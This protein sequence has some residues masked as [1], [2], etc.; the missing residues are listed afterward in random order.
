[1]EEPIEGVYFDWLCA[2]VLTE[3]NSVY[4]ELMNILYRTEFEWIVV[5]DENRFAEGLELREYFLHES[6]FNNDSEW[7]SEPCSTLEALIAFANRASFQTDDPLREWFWRFMNNLGLDEYRQVGI[8]DE[9]IIEEILSTFIWRT[10]DDN[11][12]GG[13]FPLRTPKRDQTKVE[14]WYQFC[15]YLVDQGLL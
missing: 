10:Y 11:G 12:G 1:M 15:D 6:G 4:R 14:I 13:L 7:Y 5:G 2:K 9:P 3:N 8:D